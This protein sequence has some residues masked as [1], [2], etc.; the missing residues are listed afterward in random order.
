MKKLRVLTYNI[1]KGFSFG[2]R[3]FVLENLRES[4]RAVD[5]DVVCLQEVI[6]EHSAHAPDASQFEYLADKM[7]SYYAYG[8]NAVYTEGHHGNA[9]LSRYPIRKWENHDLSLSR[10]ERRGLLHA[11][12]E[13]PDDPGPVHL[14]CMHL[15]LLERDRAVQ[16]GRVIA[17][18]KNVLS[19]EDPVI[20]AGDFNDWRENASEMLRA[21]LHLKE[22]FRDSPL[23]QH[24]RTFPSFLPLLKLDRIYYRNFACLGAKALRG[25]VWAKLSDHLPLFSEFERMPE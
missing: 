4:I 6:G 11:T 14:F 23:K 5:A 10:F 12:I 7:W 21:Q 24:A 13:D 2:N 25:G 18:L 20:L 9:I 3:K 15:N 1:H 17:H 16:I 22:V 8:K 19:T